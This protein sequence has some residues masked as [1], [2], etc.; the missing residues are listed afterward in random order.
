MTKKFASIERK[1]RRERK[2]TD[3]TTA[4]Q[5]LSPE[6][7]FKYISLL[8]SMR[9]YTDNVFYQHQLGLLDDEYHEWSLPSMVEIY[10]RQ[11]KDWNLPVGR[12][13]FAD[14]VDR[15]LERQN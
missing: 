15:I 12:K 4:I 3:P 11:W 2:R 8:S 14:A 7:R 10:G 6:E 1:Y 5:A 9:T 13:S